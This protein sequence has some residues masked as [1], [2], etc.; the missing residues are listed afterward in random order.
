ML[1][2]LQWRKLSSIPFSFSGFHGF[3]LSCNFLQSTATLNALP[4]AHHIFGKLLLL[5]RCTFVLSRLQG[6]I[7]GPTSTDWTFFFILPASIVRL[8]WDYFLI[9]IHISSS[10]LYKQ[11][12]RCST[13]AFVLRLDHYWRVDA[14]VVP[15][16]QCKEI[17]GWVKVTPCFVL[18]QSPTFCFFSALEI[19]EAAKCSGF[20]LTTEWEACL[21]KAE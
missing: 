5:R 3:A 16:W 17:N 20:C 18:P 9:F 4:R 21:P 10:C 6:W 1:T 11:C 19:A 13:T 2:A 12:V 7:T 15:W 8:L 14:R